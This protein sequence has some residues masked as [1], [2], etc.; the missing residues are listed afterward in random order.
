MQADID[1]LDNIDEDR[2]DIINLGTNITGSA[3][4][5][6][7]GALVAGPL[8]AVLGGIAGPL[9]TDITQRLISHKEKTRT[10]ALYEYT[11]HR[12]KTNLEN[13]MTVRN[14]DFWNTDNH[15]GINEIMEGVVIASQREHEEKKLRY[16]GNLMGN[17][18]FDASVSRS[19]GNLLI[20]TADGLS[21][22]Q[23]CLLEIS[24]DDN[25][26]NRLRTQA[27]GGQPL[28]RSLVSTA[29]ELYDL[30][31][32]GLVNA[33]EF[34]TDMSVMVPSR[35]KAEGT[36]IK[37]VQLMDLGAIP[38]EDIEDTINVLAI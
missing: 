35:L 14:D 30:D 29:H 13:G 32:L 36:G 11:A 3:T 5:A 17:I 21:Y 22:R 16:Y 25:K 2:R 38:D 8:G 33:G 23:L 10:G 26:R 7:A 20:R 12:I 28:A 34:Y 18:A 37:L 24:A 1:P 27:Y 31:R 4:A 19:D 15:A 6:L 9:L